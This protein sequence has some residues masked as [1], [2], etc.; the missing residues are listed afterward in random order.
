MSKYGILFNV[1]KCIACQTCFVACK[2]EN[3]LHPQ[4]KWMRIERREDPRA[5]II[6][7]FRAS[8]QHCEDPACM[9]VCPAKA[10]SKGSFGEVLVND[11]K[12]IGC[13]MCL[14]A[15]PYGAPQ[16]NETGAVSYWPDKAPLAERASEMHQ[17]RITGKAEHC[18]L[19]THRTSKGLKPACV[20]ACG[21]GAMTLVDYE[22]P[23]PEM[24]K[25]I[26]Q[27]KA[28]NVKAGTKPKIRYI[29]THMDVESYELKL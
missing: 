9:K 5:R 23:T 10:I 11:E 4:M 25:L 12:C 13:R 1:D 29:A 16:F 22:S 3:Q 27:A 2:E 24:E 28:M 26:A 8:C 21:I 15:C 20:E 7:Y 6:N 19:C 14:A 18:T 17:K